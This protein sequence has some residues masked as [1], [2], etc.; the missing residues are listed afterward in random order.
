MG[1]KRLPGKLDNTTFNFASRISNPTELVSHNINPNI[2]QEIEPL[3][4]PTAKKFN[5]Q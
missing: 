3:Q 1:N 4:S 5:E 2:E